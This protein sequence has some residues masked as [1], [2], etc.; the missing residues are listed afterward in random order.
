MAKLIKNKDCKEALMQWLR[1]AAGLN[2]E[3][4]KMFTQMPV[5]SDGFILNL[6]DVLLIFSKPFT[7]KFG[8]YPVQF[9][10]VNMLYLHDDSY[11]MNASKLEKLDG[12]VL[13]A[14][15]QGDVSL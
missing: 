10:K 4:Q 13:T 3:K 14:L 6:I 2:Q 5:A 7:T 15:K 1:L 12:D 8:D 9:P 11:V